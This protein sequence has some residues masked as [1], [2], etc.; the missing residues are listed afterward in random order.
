MT[1]AEV[2][3]L[4]GQLWDGS[5]SIP[6]APIFNDVSMDMWMFDAVQEMSVRGITVGCGN[7]NFCRSYHCRNRR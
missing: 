7:G 1:R 5:V 2:A 4:F 3:Y 6:M